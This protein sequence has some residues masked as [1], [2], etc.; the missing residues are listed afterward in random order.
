MRFNWEFYVNIN[1]DLLN[2]GINNEETAYEHFKKYGIKEKRIYCDV[3]IFFNW[4]S[5]INNNID[6]KHISTELEAW[7]HFLYHGK[8]EQRKINNQDYLI[9]Y[10]I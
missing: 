4:N 10:C 3:A 2:N 6:L 9:Q 5:Y 8:K 7:K 1:I